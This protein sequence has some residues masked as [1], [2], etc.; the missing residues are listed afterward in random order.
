[1]SVFGKNSNKHVTVGSQSLLQHH[2]AKSICINGWSQN[3]HHIQITLPAARKVLEK[4]LD[5]MYKVFCDLYSDFRFQYF[6]ISLIFFCC[7]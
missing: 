5:G 3:G 1:M 6:F 7:T 4:I 2:Y